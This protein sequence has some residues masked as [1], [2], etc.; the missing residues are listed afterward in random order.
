MKGQMLDPPIKIVKVTR[1][2]LLPQTS[3]NPARKKG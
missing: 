1:V 2:K 3:A